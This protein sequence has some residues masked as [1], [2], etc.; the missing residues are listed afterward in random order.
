MQPWGRAFAVPSP[1]ALLPFL[2]AL[3]APPAGPPVACIFG[4][5]L[6]GALGRGVLSGGS[7]GG[8][9]GNGA[10]DLLPLLLDCC[11]ALRPSVSIIHRS[12]F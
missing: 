3:M 11:T 12:T 5:E 2:T 8:G 10:G 9:D 7:G 6:L 1:S 4:R